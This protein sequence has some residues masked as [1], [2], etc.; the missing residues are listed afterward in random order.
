MNLILYLIASLII[1]IG[2]WLQFTPGI[3]LITFGF[4]IILYTL[5]APIYN[6]VI[7]Y[8]EYPNN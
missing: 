2:V 7:D 4:L 8:I 5:L 3:A 6:I 1:S